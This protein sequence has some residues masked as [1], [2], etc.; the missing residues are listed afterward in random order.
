MGGKSIFSS[1]DMKAGFH[2]IDVF[3]PHRERT[4]FTTFCGLFQFVR[5][6]FGLSGAPTTFQRVMESLRRHLSAACLIYLDD[7]IIA[8]EDEAQHLKDVENFLVMI[9][10]VG[11]TL[12]AKKCQFGKAELK[13]LGF[14]VSKDGIKPDPH[15]IET[16]QKFEPPK[17]LT[18]L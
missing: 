8:S 7:V 5:T 11:L 4:A 3:A 18:G 1:F 16:I 6:P 14:V 17:T 10:K 2:Q 13:Y 9:E 12:N 15:N